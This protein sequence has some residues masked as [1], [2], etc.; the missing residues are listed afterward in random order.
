MLEPPLW[1]DEDFMKSDFSKSEAVSI[2]FRSGSYVAPV[3]VVGH[4]PAR[5]ITADAI[6][7]A[8]R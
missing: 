8:T 2:G 6:K 4:Q 3:R 1:F 7:A 5:C